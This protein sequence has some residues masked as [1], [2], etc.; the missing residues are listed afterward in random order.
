MYPRTA[1]RSG[2]RDFRR[3]LLARIVSVAGS[4][5]ALVAM[6]LLAYQL[7]GSAAWTAAVAAAEALPY[8]MLG[9]LA[10]AVADAADRRALMIGADLVACAALASIP[11]AWGL[12][13]LGPVQV[14]AVAVVTQAAFVFFDAANFGAL[15]TLVGKGSLTSAYATLY[16]ATTVVE[17]VV[18][19]LAGLLVVVAAPAPLIGINAATALASALLVRSITGRL[20]PAPVGRRDRRLVAD[21]A[22]GL[23]FIWHNRIVRTLTLVGTTNAVAG[24]AWVAMLVPWADQVLGIR[25][26]GDAR[27]ALL[28]TCFGVGGIAASRL[29]PVLS[30]RLGGAR[31]AL[32]ALP[33]ALL[34]CTL[35]I[36]SGHWGV[37]L[38]AAIAWGVAHSTVVL[39]AITYRQQ[40]CPLDRQA[41]VNTTARMLSWGI[42]A[43]S[44][45]ALAGAVAVAGPGPRGG[46][47]A[48]GLALAVGVALAWLT[49]T[50]R[51][52]ARARDQTGVS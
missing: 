30:E 23:R 29:V 6:P 38:P 28:F 32:G 26:T 10:G 44:G 3:Y 4:L 20:S 12:G 49:P 8:L 15:P 43:P 45:A 17:L 27:L 31:L 16:G 7:T 21:V 2:N 24:G 40:V 1:D 25:P 14:V 48:G 34:C 39:N 50:L 11:V 22:E 47:V 41:R 18:P 9:L 42:G 36:A 13:G 51:G 35:V 46:L 19:P 37:A 52:A 5:V 33:T